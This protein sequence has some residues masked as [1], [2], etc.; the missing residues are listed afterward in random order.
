MAGQKRGALESSDYQLLAQF[1]YLLARFLAFSE[2]AARKSGLAPRHHQ[3]LLA[4][5]GYPDGA[6]VTVGDL[7]ERLCIRHHSAVGLVDRLERRGYLKRAADA[8][9]KRRMILTLTSKGENALAALS[10]A[11]RDELRR[12]T[13]LLKPLLAKLESE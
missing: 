7:A 11:H 2:D 13:P 10:A 1:R 3:A 12:L 6:D 4:I 5:K 8:D 9:D